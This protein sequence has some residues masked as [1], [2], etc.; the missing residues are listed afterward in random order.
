[1]LV[2]DHPMWRRTL[3]TVIESDPR[4]RVV[5]E[6]EDGERVVATAAE[7]APELVV[8]DVNLPGLGGHDA[9]RQLLEASPGIRVLVLS[10]SDQRADVVA[11]VRAGARGYLLKTAEPVDVLDA[12]GRV[13]QGEVVLP[14]GVAQLVVD[15]LRDP[16]SAPASVVAE[17]HRILVADPAAISREGLG[18][19]LRDVGFD[20]VDAVGSLAAV[21]RAIGAARCDVLVVG[22][23]LAG[24]SGLEHAVEIVR[25]AE[26][27]VGLLV[28]TSAAD[29]AAAATLL[30]RAPAGAGY[31]LAQRLTD[32]DELTEAVNR[33]A[34]GHAVVDPAVAAALLR[35]P[36]RDPL[37]TLTGREREVLALMAEGRSNQ[38][39]CDRLVLS[40][41]AVEGHVRNIFI[42]LGLDP[43]PDDHR[44]VLAVLAY[45]RAG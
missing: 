2:D 38:A 12:L 24:G 10:A 35:P 41:K 16:S 17:G 3:R 31:L 29:A 20:V 9:T 34:A 44:R 5:A 8:M 13:H 28:L 37:G 36:G 19:V 7:A 23:G 21:P 27:P 40:A 43:A 42:K 15:A 4:F 1:M 26:Q 32:A 25:Q 30:D 18:K 45:L 6:L 14:S 22:L 11:A 39:I 33:I